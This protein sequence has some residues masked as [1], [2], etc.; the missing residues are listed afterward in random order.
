VANNEDSSARS[1]QAVELTSPAD[2]GG[3][4]AE[5]IAEVVSGTPFD[6]WPYA[7]VE[8]V[9]LIAASRETLSPEAAF[10][11]AVSYL[12]H[13]VEQ[14]D[15]AERTVEK[16]TGI[17]A[18]F[19][20]YID[21][22]YGIVD[23]RDIEQNQVLAFINASVLK[24][25]L[26]LVTGRTKDNRRWAVD[27]FF[28]TLRGL[29]LYEGDPLLDAAH[30]ARE[31]TDFRPLLDAEI[32]RCRKVA[33]R[34]LD[35]TLRPVRFALAEAMAATAEIPEVLVAD[36]DASNARV[37]L[38]GSPKRIYGRWLPL[39][40]HEVE[41]I[42]RRIADLGSP[43]PDVRLAYEGDKR[44]T[45]RE[46]ATSCSLRA[47]LARAGLTRQAHPTV[48]PSSIRAWGARRLFDETRDV[49]L[50]AHRLGVRK[51]DD[52]LWIIGLPR[53]EPDVPPPHRRVQ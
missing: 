13:L 16:A 20:R 42:E 3:L 21:A 7:A 31:S 9:F 36:Y 43:R 30:F 8:D 18:R 47:V 44:F 38:D 24:H 11:L 25:E 19:V 22:R 48:R 27:L 17:I 14:G 32:E 15:Y 26:H 53:P 6:G 28:R 1:S 23:V 49:Q 50:V 10:A 45:S 51:I 5:I 52:A 41:V 35:D 40:P 46:S 39:L 37:W 12:S 33:P 34:R 4:G 29:D 2:L